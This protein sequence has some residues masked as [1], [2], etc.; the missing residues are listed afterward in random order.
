MMSDDLLERLD[1]LAEHIGDDDYHIPLGSKSAVLLAIKEIERL[2]KGPS[3]WEQDHQ[4]RILESLGIAEE[5]PFGCDAIEYV[6][7]ALIASR[8]EVER[9][10]AELID[11]YLEAFYEIAHDEGDGWY[12]T[13][14]RQT[15]VWH[16]DRLVELGVFEEDQSRGVGR[17]RYYR[18]KAAIAAE[19]NK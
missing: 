4:G 1:H 5:F 7:K 16:G 17:V 8:K 6:G 3:G 12:S 2:R 19:R 10:R 11:T 18:P 15:C 14:A 9:L 13:N